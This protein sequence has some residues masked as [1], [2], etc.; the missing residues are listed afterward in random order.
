MKL[1]AAMIVRNELGRYLPIVVDNL[2][3][4][5]DEIR[6]WDDASDD[7]TREWLQQHPKV[8]VSGSGRPRFYDNEGH[9]R[10]ML[11]EWTLRG[12]PTHVLSVDADE[13]VTHGEQLREFA[14]GDMGRGVWSLSMEEVWAASEQ[15]LLIRCDGL[16]KAQEHGV[17]ALWRAPQGR[18]TPGGAWKMLP[19]KLACGREPIAV[20]RLGGAIKTGASIL[21]LGWLNPMTREQRYQ[22]YVEHD[23]GRFHNR[24]HLDSIVW[25]DDR[26]K[27]RQR[28]W[29]EG[30]D[31]AAVLE[32]AGLAVPA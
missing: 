28:T 1:V 24:R 26:V 11:L 16:W 32:A 22:R 21:H 18:H 5:V 23:G 20:R 15:S 29:P 10:N 31:R 12:K 2:A 7:G 27:V 30:V 9:A 4:F 13:V 14:E 8:E 3:G 17:G 19:R 6:V 25:T